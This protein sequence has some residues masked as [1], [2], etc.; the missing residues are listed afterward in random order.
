M[1]NRKTIKHLAAR[2]ITVVALALAVG[3]GTGLPTTAAAAE[4]ASSAPATGN[5]L[6]AGSDW[7][8]VRGRGEA[9]EDGMALAR[10]A[11][12]KRSVKLEAGLYELQINGA[13]A[14]MQTG[15]QT[16]MLTM[17]AGTRQRTLPVVAEPG[18]YGLLF[19]VAQPGDVELAL[20]YQVSTHVGRFRLVSTALVAADAERRAAWAAAKES[21]KMLGYYGTDPQRPA[22]GTAKA[23]APM[24]TFSKANLK[25]W[26]IRETVVFYDPGYDPHMI[27]DDAGVAAFFTRRG[28]S[29]KNAIEAEAWLKARAEKDAGM[30]SSIIFTMGNA[31]ANIVYPPFADCLLAKYM[32]AG[33]RVVWMVNVPMYVAQAATGTKFNY[34]KAASE[35]MLGLTTDRKTFYGMPGPTTLTPAAKAWGLEPAYLGLARAVHTRSVTIPFVTDSSGDYSSTGLVNLRRDIPFSGFIFAPD[36]VSGKTTRLLANAYR[37]AR[38]SGEPVKV[39][40]AAPLPK[41]AIPLEADLRFGSK[42]QRMV[43]LRGEVVPLVLRLRALKPE[44]R[45]VGVHYVLREGDAV[46]REDT[47]TVPVSQKEADKMIA[48]LDLRG[49]RVGRY[50]VSA[51]LDID[52]KSMP[53]TRELRIAPQPD[54]R[55]THIAVWCSASP[56]TNRTEYLLDDLAAHNVE[57]MFVGHLPIGRDL[58]LWYG[59]S[60]STRRHGLPKTLPNPPGYD[61]YRRGSTGRILR[62]RAW[63]NKRAA[64]GYA[65][66]LRRQAEADDFGRQVAE[67]NAAFPAFRKRTVTGDDYSQWFGMDY[68]RYAVEGF[69]ARY[70]FEPPRPKGTEDPYQTPNVERAAGIIPDDDPWI[71]LN[72]YWCETLGDA[73]RRFSRAMESATGGVGKVGPIPGAMQIPVIGMWSGQYPTFNFGAK[74]GFNMSSFYYYNSLWQPPLA[75]VWWLESARM[76][77]RDI[78][79][80]IMPDCYQ[81]HLESFYRNN[82]WLMLSGGAQGLPYF[83]YS[84]R[85]PEP[86]RAL[87][88]FGAWSKRYGLML[89]KLRPAPKKVAMLV[90]FENVV[91]QFEYGYL[92]AYPFMNLLL[93]KVDA[94]PVSPEEL[95]AVN[96]R[97]YETVV[98]TQIKW[99]KAGTV[100]LL[101]DYIAGG[102]KV[103]LGSV[104]AAA[105]AVKGAIVLDFPIGQTPRTDYG[106]ADRIARVRK[107]MLPISKP[108]VDCD[109]PFVTVRRAALP[110]GTPGVWL[111]HN[112][113]RDEY[114]RLLAGKDL[115]P[116]DARALETQ[117]GYRKEIVSTTITRLDDGRIPFDVFGGRVL[118]AASADGK[119]TVKLEIPKWEGMLIVFLPALPARIDLVG[120]PAET[121]PGLAVRL[122][123]YV[124]DK[125]GAVLTTPMPLQLTLRDPNGKENREYRR[126]LLTENGSATH[127]FTFAVNDLRGA[128][129]LEVEDV[130]TGVKVT[131]K[132]Q[133][134]KQ[135]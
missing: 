40:A 6:P 50:T 77:N 98:L 124:R 43:Y 110:D 35:Q 41:P 122:G 120:M 91:Y 59:F 27:T 67:L 135:Q 75:H 131:R 72:R 2:T 118:E 71:L 54:H 64:K 111:V 132:I 37:L 1:N 88:A 56:K 86:M 108:V 24:A 51:N 33:G 49:L 80:W 95:D 69:R 121:G 53:I 47:V 79:Q 25:R 74:N 7:V 57:P 102:G 101:E 42:N 61:N 82:L 32:R 129:T 36:V 114:S 97:A 17:T 78:E 115:K 39:P 104:T 133:L 10:G 62:V 22:P 93:A 63:G 44:I 127:S 100:R 83:H 66:P 76:G 73:G 58:A 126:R 134:R 68:N 5:L 48:A 113:T 84:E 34:G 21:Y 130:L 103:V 105:I 125:A 16:G 52:G 106:R 3:Y 92:M 117:L 116:A 18:L 87:K 60:Y 112:Y 89:D 11:Q 90:P 38:F 29:A 85:K 46:L 12:L 128:W 15:T 13:G 19:E 107:A 70:G 99:L 123:V 94:E 23:A 8:F 65:S 119:M 28:L 81:F 45:K 55:G 109:A 4:P 30:G 96:I 9:T 20:A 31:P 26:A 14:G